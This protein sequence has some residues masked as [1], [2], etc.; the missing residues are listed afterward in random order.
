M[1]VFLTMLFIAISALM[2]LVVLVQRGRGGGLSGAFGG[3]GGSNSAFGTKVG[4]VFTWVTVILFVCFLLFA[5]GLNY[6]YRGEKEHVTISG[7]PAAP[8]APTPT[9]TGPASTDIPGIHP[10]APLVPPATPAP[11]PSTPAST[12][13]K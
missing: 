12:Q 6:A 3:G 5:I 11:L 8:L 2:V 10:N 7:T 9:T 1:V 4:D 13:T